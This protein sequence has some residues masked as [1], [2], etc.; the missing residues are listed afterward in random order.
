[1]NYYKM[2]AFT[3]TV[4]NAAQTIKDMVETANSGTAWD[5][6]TGLTEI[7][8][9]VETNSIR[10][11]PDGSTPTT[12]TGLKYTV[13]AEVN[14]LHGSLEKMLFIRNGGSNA[15]VTIFVGTKSLVV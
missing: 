14:S 1:M 5:M 8:F 6:P 3:V 12:S 9:Q 2:P 7:H 11:C 10:V 15:T 13:G 4:T